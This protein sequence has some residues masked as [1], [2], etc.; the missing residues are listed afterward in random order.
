MA[1]VVEIDTRNFNRMVKDLAFIKGKDLQEVIRGEA[2]A[3]LE[4]SIRTTKAAKVSTIR[5]RV[6]KSD[7]VKHNGKIYN[8]RHRLPNTI[9]KG[10]K[11]TR[12]KRLARKL[13]ARGTAKGTYY[14][15]ARQLRLNVNAPAYVA[16]A[17]KATRAKMGAALS[18]T[19]TGTSRFTITIRNASIVAMKYHA[20]GFRAFTRALNGRVSYFRKQMQFG[21]K[22]RAKK[23]AKGNAKVT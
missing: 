11:E 23:A 6:N 17:A 9:W 18:G 16:K 22:E 8:T 19:E 2:K 10:I 1:R 3:I 13:A 14:T 7:F 15:I 4:K 5:N 12:K 20:G 21:F